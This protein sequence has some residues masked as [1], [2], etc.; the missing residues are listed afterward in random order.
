[1]FVG[2]LVVIFINDII[3]YK[4]KINLLFFKLF[5]KREKK[6]K[7]KVGKWIVMVF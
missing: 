4:E 3:I 1:M 6:K 7:I 5:K 2:F